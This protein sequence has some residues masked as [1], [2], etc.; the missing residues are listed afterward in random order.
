[1]PHLRDLLGAGID[2]TYTGLP[3]ELALDVLCAEGPDLFDLLAWSNRV[4]H[5]FKG[6]GVRLC[7]I[8]NAKSGRC[9][10]DCAFCAQSARSGAAIERHG[11]RSADELFEA[12]RAA[13]AAGAARFGIV[14]SGTALGRAEL[15][16]VASALSRIAGELPI[17]PCASLGLLGRD[18]LE[19]LRD[20]GLTRYHHN[21][22]AAES[23][24]PE[25]CSTRAWTRSVDT[26]GAARLAGLSTCCGGIF[27]VGESRAQ[28]IELLQEV[29]ELGV[30]SVPINFLHPIPGTPL[31]RCAGL[32]ALEALAVVAVARLMM[33]DR[34]IRVCGGRE[35]ALR[36]LQ[37]W[38][39]LAGADG[40]MVG[41]YLTTSGRNV[42]DDLRMIAD[43]GLRLAGPG[44]AGPAGRGPPRP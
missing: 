15:R 11:L 18:A 26:I 21:L 12:A 43:A 28:R 2:A 5:L 13:A 23:F 37:S 22:E 16:V 31:E 19:A 17:A 27:G 3:R 44:A 9:A 25:L 33:P 35:H 38:V 6:Q 41:G 24:F 14:T 30:D 8:A 1:V 32:T 20:A 4:R 34:E 39:V 42:A 40:I 10:E 7:S 29:R 36:D